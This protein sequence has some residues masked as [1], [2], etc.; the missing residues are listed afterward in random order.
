LGQGGP[1]AGILALRP[2][3]HEI[4]TRLLGRPPAAGFAV[5]VRRREGAPVVI[6][7]EPFLDDGRPMPTRWWLVD[8]ALCREVAR[9]EAGG[10][11]RAAAGAVD[12]AELARA[13]DAYAAARDAAARHAAARDAGSSRRRAGRRPSGGVG[14]TRCGVKC[15]HAHLAWWLAGGD[16]P[17]GRWTARQLEVERADFVVE[18]PAGRIGAGGVAGERGQAPVAALDCG[19]NSTRLLVVDGAGRALD[20]QMRIT[21]L[22]EGVDATGRLSAPAVARTVSV[23]EDYR[24]RMDELGVRRARLVATSAARDAA[25]AG[26]FLDAAARATGLE[27]EVLSGDEEGRL[28]FAGA[29]AALPAGFPSGEP[30]LV[31]DIG[32]GS[33]ELVVGVPGDP[34]GARVLSL[35]V[36]CVRVSERFLVGDPPTAPQ[37]QRAAGEVRSVLAAARRRLPALE[38]AGPV[39]GLAGTVSTLAALEKGL[40]TYDRERVHHAVLGRERVDEWLSVLASETAARRT[41]RPGMLAGRADVIVGGVLVLSLVMEVFDRSWCLASEDDILDGLAASLLG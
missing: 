3:D 17:V 30:V 10:G 36:G 15:L 4:V 18:Q 39:V 28:S 41:A 25:N 8:P 16:D 23:L 22:G 7:N 21:R 14:G 27:P 9:L 26:D 34:G 11:V 32:G 12:P 33:T 5:A 2:D 6:V 19:T 1:Y 24:A 20:R 35:D 40:C 13:H 31:V 29:T 37:L 38:P